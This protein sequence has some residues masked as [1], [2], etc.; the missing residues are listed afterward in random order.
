MSDSA[1]ALPYLRIGARD[2]DRPELLTTVLF[3]LDVYGL[4]RFTLLW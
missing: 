1:M 3:S 4:T 2:G